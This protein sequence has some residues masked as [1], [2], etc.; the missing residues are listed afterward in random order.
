MLASCYPCPTF[1]P[2]ITFVSTYTATANVARIAFAY[3]RQNYYFALDTISVRDIATPNTEI[4]TNGGFETGDLTGWTYCNQNNGSITGGVKA[5]NSF[6]YSNFTYYPQSG[7][8]YYL[9]G[10]IIAADYITQSFPTTNG[11]TYNISL[12]TMFPGSGN[13]T[14]ANL[15][16]GV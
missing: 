3:Q 4:L 15:F 8:Y 9:A 16:I 7:S 5:N 13:F 6:S 10:N 11:H 2:Y 14:S 1:I 12:W